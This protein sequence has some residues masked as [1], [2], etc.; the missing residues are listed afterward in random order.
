MKYLDKLGITNYT[1]NP[2]G[3]IDV[4]GDLKLYNKKLKKLLVRFN[5]VDGD[6]WIYKNELTDLTGC[7]KYVG[8]DFLC[9]E[10]RL[11]S[12]KGC[13]EYVGRDFDIDVNLLTSLEFSP[14]YVGGYFSCSNNNLTDNY[15]E[16]EIG[17]NFYTSL[18]QTGLSINI[19]GKSNYN[20][21][22]KLTRR[23]I[24]LDKLFSLYLYNG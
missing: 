7:P 19:N 12:L 23:K 8:G 11:T 2:D 10:N 6:F 17:E 22:R 3:T 16:T 24:I 4:K 20:E 9:Y 14:N 5:R 1:I 15:C 18:S 13:P 21:W